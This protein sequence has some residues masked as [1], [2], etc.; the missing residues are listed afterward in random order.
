MGIPG[1]YR[2]SDYEGKVPL[3]LKVLML[4]LTKEQL[5]P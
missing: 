2:D 4:T 3:S 5:A 1:D